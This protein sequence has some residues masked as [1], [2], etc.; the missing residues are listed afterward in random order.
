MFT[1]G[2]SRAR[3]N[4]GLRGASED[5]SDLPLSA[6]IWA[7]FLFL[8]ATPACSNGMPAQASTGWCNQKWIELTGRVVDQGSLLSPTAES[9]LTAMLA[10]A[11][12]TTGHQIVFVTVPDLQANRIEDYSLCLARHW[13]IGRVGRND[14]VLVL[15]ARSEK[16]MRIE[17]G[18]GLQ[19][20]FRDDEVALIIEKIFMPKLKADDFDAAVL[21]G[22]DAILKEIQ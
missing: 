15:L 5:F 2:H 17:I 10:K 19:T 1:F 7:S 13:E 9:K 4:S 16:N 14:G 12:K 20:A 6:R 21:A 11:E 22:A 18:D 8:L 3:G